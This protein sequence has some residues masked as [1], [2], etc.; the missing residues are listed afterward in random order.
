MFDF[1][2]VWNFRLCFSTI[3]ISNS[4]SSDSSAK[5]DLSVRVQLHKAELPHTG[6]INMKVAL[7]KGSEKERAPI[8][9]LY[10]NLWRN[11]RLSAGITLW[12]WDSCQSVQGPHSNMS[13]RP[14]PELWCI[15]VQPL[16]RPAPWQ[17]SR[18]NAPCSS[19]TNQTTP[20]DASWR[21]TKEGWTPHCRLISH[22][23][24]R[25][26]T[27]HWGKVLRTYKTFYKCFITITEAS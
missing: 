5:Q 27:I 23:W 15:S 8:S 22:T 4:F 16:G 7:I 2:M 25:Y 19:S 11:N 13:K 9:L 12:P 6:S 3:A 1:K 24:G 14:Y 26:C 20:E 17:G 21:S 18:E 10:Y